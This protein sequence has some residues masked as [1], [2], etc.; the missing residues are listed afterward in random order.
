MHP[1]W[2]NLCRNAF[3]EDPFRKVAKEFRCDQDM[4]PDIKHLASVEKVAWRML[5][6]ETKKGDARRRAAAVS[7]M[8]QDLKCNGGKLVHRAV[9]FVRGGK[10][11]FVPPTEVITNKDGEFISGPI[12]IPEIFVEE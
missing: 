1:V 12:K 6:D 2:T 10:K 9:K 5:E 8:G 7:K 11:E 3:A 4:P